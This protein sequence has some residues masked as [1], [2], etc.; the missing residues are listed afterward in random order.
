MII[1]SENNSWHTSLKRYG[2]N[3]FMIMILHAMNGMW[4]LFL[5][6]FETQF[7]YIDAFI[8]EIDSYYL[9][10]FACLFF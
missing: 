5:S 6:F 10:C 4:N 2:T 8:P 7:L 1:K 3:P 9:Y